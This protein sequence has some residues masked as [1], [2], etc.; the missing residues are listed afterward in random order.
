MMV[1]STVPGPGEVSCAYRR[2]T[3]PIDKTAIR[4]AVERIM[5]TSLWLNTTEVLEG[6]DSAPRRTAKTRRNLGLDR[7]GRPAT[8]RARK[9]NA[10]LCAPTERPHRAVLIGCS[11]CSTRDA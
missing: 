2:F 1:T 3:P 7:I 4:I 10:C 8:V 11:A 6:K 9:Q 5:K